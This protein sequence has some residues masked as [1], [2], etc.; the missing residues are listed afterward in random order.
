VTRYSQR[1][2]K[3]ETLVSD[4]ARMRHRLETLVRDFFS[5]KTDS[6]KLA[7]MVE[8]ECG[9]D[10]MSSSFYEAYA[11]WEGV[12]RRGELRDIFDTIQFG[13]GLVPNYQSQNIKFL[14]CASRILDEEAVGYRI[15]ENAVVYRKVD[16]AFESVRQRLIA[17]L[18]VDKY[19]AARAHLKAVDKALLHSPMDGRGAIRGIFDVIENVFKQAFVGQTHV[20][21]GALNSKLKPMIEN[22]FADDEQEKRVSIKLFDGFTNWVNAVHFYRHEAGKPE[23]HQPQEAT[24]L[25]LVSQGYSHARWLI[26]I[27]DAQI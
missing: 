7:K 11:D 12:F 6:H 3:S 23:P 27:V 15:D 10:V 22:M 1:Y 2:E 24:A 17:G 20:N 14:E 5:A 16:G 8:K 18:D 21:N 4:S 13:Y 19:A 25:V 9:I 26:G